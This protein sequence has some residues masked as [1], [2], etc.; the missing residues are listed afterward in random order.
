M[1]DISAVTDCDF[2]PVLIILTVISE[3]LRPT[4]LYNTIIVNE[5]LYMTYIS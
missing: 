4:Q 2:A 1:S 3:L 5:H